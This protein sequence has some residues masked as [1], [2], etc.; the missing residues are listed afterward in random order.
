MRKRL[1]VSVGT[2]PVGLLLFEGRKGRI[3][4][5]MWCYLLTYDVTDYWAVSI[6]LSEVIHI[7]LVGALPTDILQFPP[8]ALV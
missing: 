7:G 2:S 4:K 8:C 1:W 3:W 5:I 6:V